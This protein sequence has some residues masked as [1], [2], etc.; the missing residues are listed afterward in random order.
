MGIALRDF[1]EK[2]IGDNCEYVWSRVRSSRRNEQKIKRNFTEEAAGEMGHRMSICSGGRRNTYARRHGSMLE[3]VPKFFPQK[4][5]FWLSAPPR[6]EGDGSGRKW[7][8]KKNMSCGP[9]KEHLC[10]IYFQPQCS[11][12][13][14]ILTASHHIELPLKLNLGGQVLRLDPRHSQ[15]HHILVRNVLVAASVFVECG[16]VVVFC[17]MTC[18]VSGQS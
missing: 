11:A 1:G 12:S 17:S 13:Q 15:V 9:V 2:A 16:G 3:H 8:E 14:L 10:H 18:A 6:S 5:I 4:I 7:W